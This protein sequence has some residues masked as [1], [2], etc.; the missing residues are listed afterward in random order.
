MAA[1]LHGEHLHQAI[2]EGH[3]KVTAMMWNF[4]PFDGDWSFDEE[5]RKL[6]A[7][8]EEIGSI[9]AWAIDVAVQV[10]ALPHCGQVNFPEPIFAIFRGIGNK[11]PDPSFMFCFE[12]SSD[13]KA[14]VK[15]YAEVLEGWLQGETNDA[16]LTKWPDAKEFITKT[17]ASLGPSTELKQL[18]VEHIALY[19]RLSIEELTTNDEG[20]LTIQTNSGNIKAKA[21]EQRQRL[22]EVA[23]HEGFDVNKF[24]SE[25]D[26]PWLCHQRLFD[27]IDVTLQRIGRE[28][29]H[30]DQQQSRQGAQEAANRM[31]NVYD[32]C[33]NTLT[34]W[35]NG[36]ELDTSLQKN[37]ETA[38]ILANTYDVLGEWTPVKVW[39]ASAF[40]KKMAL[41]REDDLEYALAV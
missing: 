3:S 21:E 5:I 9:P 8:E 32:T 28:E 22:V 10:D 16:V 14:R 31:R 6:I 23:N 19:L 25:M 20:L 24:F 11:Q 7:M 36:E 12:A 39:L 27:Q 34:N 17:Y 29:S 4:T 15:R 18:L 38:T 13:T 37:P 1:W 33:I 26:H 30:Y 2:R 35:L 41:F 40:R